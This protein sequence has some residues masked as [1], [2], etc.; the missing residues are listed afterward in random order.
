MRDNSNSTLATTFTDEVESCTNCVW[1]VARIRSDTAA[2]AAEDVERGEGG[3]LDPLPLVVQHPAYF[4][5]GIPRALH[6]RV[7]LAVAPRD[8]AATVVTRGTARH[9]TTVSGPSRWFTGLIE[10]LK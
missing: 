4:R 7:D 10:N 2:A 3:L 6:L 5:H 9:G 1:S 8:L